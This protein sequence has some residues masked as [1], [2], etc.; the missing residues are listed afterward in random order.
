MKRQR[1]K[2]LFRDINGREE[3]FNTFRLL[4]DEEFSKNLNVLIAYDQIVNVSLK[5]YKS[6]YCS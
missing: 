1:E 5:K 6:P 2:K 4:S 3:H